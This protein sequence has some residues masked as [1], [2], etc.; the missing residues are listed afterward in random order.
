MLGVIEDYEGRAIE[1]IERRGSEEECE[2]IREKQDE[3]KE[4]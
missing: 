4:N 2:K 3:V 1:E